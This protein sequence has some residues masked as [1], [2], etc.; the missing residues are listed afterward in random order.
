M[1]RGFGWVALGVSLL[2]LGCA[3]LGEYTIA[4]EQA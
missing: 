2:F 3:I 4:R 1:K